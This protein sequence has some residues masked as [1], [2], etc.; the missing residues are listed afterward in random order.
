KHPD[1]AEDKFGRPVVVYVH[2]GDV[3]CSRIETLAGVP[4]A[5]VMVVDADDAIH[6]A[7][8]LMDDGLLVV[9]WTDGGAAYMRHSTDGGQTW[10]DV[11]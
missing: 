9:T 1:L 10:A 4:E 7:V 5:P 2:D 3:W 11:V 6:P 8:E